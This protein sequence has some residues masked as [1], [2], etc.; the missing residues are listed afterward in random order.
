MALGLFAATLAI[1][2][3]S[4]PDRHAVELRDR[5]FTVIEDAGISPALV[6]DS[7][8]ACT[9]EFSRL[10]EGVRTLGI[11]EDEMYAFC[12]LATRQ[13]RRWSFQPQQPSAWTRLVDEAV[14]AAAPVIERVHTLPPHPEDVPEKG[15]VLT[16]WARHLLPATPTLEQVDAII[17]RPGCAAQ[18]FHPDAGDTHFR[19][20]RLNAR[21]RL[22]NAFVP[23][24]DLEAD[25]DGT[26]FWPGSHLRTVFERY[27]AARARSG[28]LEADELAMAEMEVPACPAGGLILFDFRLLHRGQPNT[29]GERAIA[30]AV[31][32]TGLAKDPL[33]YPDTSLLDA[34]KAFG[35]TGGG[36]AAEAEELR[37]AIRR[38]QQ[39]TWAAVRT[40]SFR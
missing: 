24:V 4:L 3:P 9:A 2:S 38:Q 37:E 14:A 19:L 36:R 6:A 20:A 11:E 8:S 29:S 31:L 17:S 22:Y 40:S 35:A 33:T 12:E 5:G 39:E 28:V 26:M 27:A 21:H 1:A 15:A 23:L 18:T 30:H 13:R 16:G 32:S 25:G 7:R 34:V 10:L